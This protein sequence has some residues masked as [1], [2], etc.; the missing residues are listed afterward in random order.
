MRADGGQVLLVFRLPAIKAEYVREVP[1]MQY[2]THKEPSRIKIAGR[3]LVSSWVSPP[4]L[5]SLL[6]PGEEL[7]AVYVDRGNRVAVWIHSVGVFFEVKEKVQDLPDRRLDG[8]FAIPRA[9]LM[10]FDH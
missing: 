1:D 7:V 6:K 3:H 5:F 2:F 9:E 4:Y 10:G 8:F